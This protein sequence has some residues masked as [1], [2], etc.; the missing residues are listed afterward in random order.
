M[1]G[2]IPQ[3]LRHLGMESSAHTQSHHVHILA[4][5]SQTLTSEIINDYY[6][7]LKIEFCEDLIP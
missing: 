5:W 3:G 7:S 1:L 6:H 2:E 4:G